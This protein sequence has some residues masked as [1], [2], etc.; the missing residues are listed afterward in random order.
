MPASK[1]LDLCPKAIFKAPD[2][3]LFRS[4]SD[5]IHDIFH[6]YTDKIETVALDEA[7]LDVTENKKKIDDPIYLAHLIQSEIWEN[8][9]N[10]FDRNFL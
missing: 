1:A 2:F 8:T 6:E 7:Y 5:Q 10:V 3:E 4:V 9:F